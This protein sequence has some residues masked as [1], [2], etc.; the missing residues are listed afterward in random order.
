MH[1]HI[2]TTCVQNFSNLDHI[3]MMNAFPFTSVYS[4]IQIP[5]NEGD[6]THDTLKL[7]GPLNSAELD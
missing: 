2:N 6:M 5:D 3:V 7:G 1:A 4:V